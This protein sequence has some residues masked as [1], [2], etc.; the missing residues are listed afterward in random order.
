VKS[1][2]I[3]SRTG[4]GAIVRS[5]R[6]SCQNELGYN[7][8]MASHP[9]TPVRFRWRARAAALCGF[10]A[11]LAVPLPCRGQQTG[12]RLFQEHTRILRANIDFVSDYVFRGVS[13]SGRRPA[14]QGGFDYEHARGPFAGVWGSSGSSTTPL[15]IDFYGGY[16]PEIL[17][18]VYLEAAL[19]GFVYPHDNDENA[20]EMKLGV[21]PRGFAIAWH[22]DFVLEADYF[23]A[24]YRFERDRWWFA[25]RGGILDA[26]PGDPQRPGAAPMPDGETL[27]WDWQVGLGYRIT[28]NL[29]AVGAISDQ[30]FEG[31]RLVVGIGGVFPFRI[32]ATP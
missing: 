27:A 14:I 30:R 11:L 1:P 2:S 31:E 18:D 3:V 25:G 9:A 5:G 8:P 19:T 21:N 22:H 28:E 29:R 16:A 12:P 32:D 13:L 15:E 26:G 23:E 10:L 24:G 20:M 4:D 17:R 6:L 7:P